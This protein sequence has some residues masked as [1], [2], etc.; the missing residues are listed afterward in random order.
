[1]CEGVGGAGGTSTTSD[2]TSTNTSS[3]ASTA[4]SASATG[5][6]S[7][8]DGGSGGNSGTVD[9]TSS[10]GGT[11]GSTSGTTTGTNSGGSGGGPVGAAVHGKVINHWLQPVPGVIVMVGDE[12]VETN[13]LGEFEIEEVPEIYDVMLDV[14]YPRFG[15]PARYG[16]VYQ[17]VTRRDPTLQVYGGLPLRDANVLIN[18]TNVVAGTGRVV[19]TALGG[20]YTRYDREDDSAAYSMFSYYG[21]PSITMNAYALQWVEVD[22]LPIE[23][24][25]YDDAGLLAFD[26]ESDADVEVTVDL[27][28]TEVTSGTISG[29]VASSSSE[30]RSNTVYVRFA[31]NALIQ[32]VDD[33]PGGESNFTYT[34]PS[35]PDASI[36][37]AAHEGEIFDLERA[38]AYQ[39]GV[40]PGQTGIQLEI[41]V[42]ARLSAPE[43][44]A[45]LDE[46]TVFEWTRD[47]GQAQA[48][49]WHLAA[50]SL[51]EGVFVVTAQKQVKLTS[52]ADKLELIRPGEEYSWRVETHGE[53]ESVDAMLGAE[54]FMGAFNEIAYDEPEGPSAGSGTYTSS[55]ARWV[56][57][58]P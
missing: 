1:M 50:T 12:E 52:F 14:T 45:T 18:P 35:L 55:A 9:G 25:A 43:P 48:F 31:S 38:V 29:T 53:P 36:L 22:D 37:V 17:G 24:L 42:P 32:V 28:E 39:N 7:G 19:A 21:P 33:A 30:D 20:D 41:P 15:V 44:N 8:G 49:V 58:A 23:Y 57:A 4:T 16:W 47:D 6:S 13:E 10:S 46:D 5:I 27:T 11:A 34:V 40:S 56:V 2:T 51:D 54:G 26:S 3:G